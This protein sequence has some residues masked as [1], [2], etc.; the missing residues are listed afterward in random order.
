MDE[1]IR[2]QS[3]LEALLKTGRTLRDPQVHEVSRQLER[4]LGQAAASPGAGA[5]V[6]GEA[7]PPATAPVP[8][9]RGRS[10]VIQLRCVLCDYW[11]GNGGGCGGRGECEYFQV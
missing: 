6:A 3:E 7:A 11:R 5:G 9:S 2:L 10:K 1:L 4:A 8:A